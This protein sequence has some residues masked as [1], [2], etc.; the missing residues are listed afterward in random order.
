MRKGVRFQSC[1]AKDKCVEFGEIVDVK[2][3][4]LVVETSHVLIVE[5]EL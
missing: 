4:Q 5:V 1:F 3:V 2:N